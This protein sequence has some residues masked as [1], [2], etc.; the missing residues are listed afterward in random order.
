MTVDEMQAAVEAILYAAGEPLEATRIAEALE[1]SMEDV[2]LI[3]DRLSSQLDER[4][5]GLCLLKM[6]ERYQLCTRR[7]YA[8]I[9][10]G[11]LEI[12]KNAPLSPAAF[13][14]LAIV[15]YNQPVTKSYVEQV[16]GVDCSGVVTTLCQKGLL[17]EQGRLELPGRPL[18]YGTTSEFLKCFCISSLEELPALPEK[19]DGEKEESPETQA[20]M[21]AVM[22]QN[23]QRNAEEE[24][25]YENLKN[26]EESE[27]DDPFAQEIAESVE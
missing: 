11:V 6:E 18:L 20:D 10:R 14:V 4:N 27:T 21:H 15:A 24:V 17:E 7:E 22:L 5:S 9:V 26:E 23:L 25:D 16:R 1:I 3:L 13:E 12:K 2:E 8:P 19:E